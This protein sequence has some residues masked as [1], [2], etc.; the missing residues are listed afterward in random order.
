MISYGCHY[1]VM[2]VMLNN[3]QQFSD[4]C[5]QNN[6][7]IIKASEY[8]HYRIIILLIEKGANVQNYSGFIARAFTMALMFEYSFPN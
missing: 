1:L 7:T 2:K 6:Q 5:I 8:G 3:N 4:V